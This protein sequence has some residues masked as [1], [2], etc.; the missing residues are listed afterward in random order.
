MK[1]NYSYLFFII[2]I[3]ICFLSFYLRIDIS[4]GALPDLATHWKYIQKINTVGLLNVFDIE[5]G[6]KSTFGL[7]SKLL[8]FP[9]HHFII[10]YYLN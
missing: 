7:D 5:L 4:G 10:S 9:L 3:T 8:N 1:I 2:S 6:D